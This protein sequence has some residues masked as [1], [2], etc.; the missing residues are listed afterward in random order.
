MHCVSTD[1]VAVAWSCTFEAQSTM[2]ALCEYPARAMATKMTNETT[3]P[4]TLEM[5]FIAMRP[6]TRDPAD[7][8]I[9]MFLMVSTLVLAEITLMR[10]P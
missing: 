8:P 9:A 7:T 1:A 2:D 10:Q 3:L 4:T 5:T 6:R